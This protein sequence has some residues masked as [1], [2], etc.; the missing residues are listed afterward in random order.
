MCQS[1]NIAGDLWKIHRQQVS[2][3]HILWRNN[4]S[5]S[6]SSNNNNNNNNNNNTS[7]LSCWG[8]VR[9]LK[10]VWKA[11]KNRVTEN[12]FVK[13]EPNLPLVAACSRLL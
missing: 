5:S 12:R 8:G 4:S 11:N 6:S 13:P 9:I 2:Y 7:I 3:L 10:H 1:D